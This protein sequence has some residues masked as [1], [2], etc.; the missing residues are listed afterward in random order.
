[1]QKRTSGWKPIPRYAGE[2]LQAPTFKGHTTLLS[3]LSVATEFRKLSVDSSTTCAGR[4]R[5][6]RRIISIAH[7]P[8][9]RARTSIPSTECGVTDSQLSADVADGSAVFCLVE[10]VDDLLRREL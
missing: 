10:G 8:R 4:A 3:E 5:Y 9:P 1:V 2:G 6:R 7:S